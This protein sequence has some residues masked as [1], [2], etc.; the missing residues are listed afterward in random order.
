VLKTLYQ[1]LMRAMDRTA[2]EPEKRKAEDAFHMEEYKQLRAVVLSLLA[3]LDAVFQYAV[4]GSAVVYS[5]VVVQGFGMSKSSPSSPCFR[6]PQPVIHIGSLIPPVLVFIMGL[7]AL[8]TWL[9]IWEMGKYLGRL[10]DLLGSSD[11]GENRLG[12]EHRKGSS[13]AMPL[14]LFAWVVLLAAVCW[15]T[16]S[17]QSIVPPPSVAC[18]DSAMPSR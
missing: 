8:T 18:P 15:A 6:L 11:G 16:C 4:I 12:W 5:W 2:D 1:L 14:T 9:R 3:R 17:V 13:G 10:E 7:F